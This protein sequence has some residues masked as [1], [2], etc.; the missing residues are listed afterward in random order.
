MQS[1][2]EDFHR[3]F[4]HPVN[5]KPVW[6]RPELRAKLI[7]E[8]A[9]ETVDAIRARNMIE[10]IDGMCDLL[11][12]VFGT[13]VEFGID[14]DVFFEE[15]HRANMT[16]VGGATRA[17][18]KTLK[19]PG[20]EPPMIEK[21]LDESYRREGV[22]QAVAPNE[23]CDI[24]DR[25]DVNGKCSCSLIVTELRR[26]ACDDRREIMRM[27]PVFNLVRRWCNRPESVITAGREVL[28]ND[29][30]LWR[31]LR[32]RMTNAIAMEPKR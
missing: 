28:A 20:W 11:Y 2:V 19:P 6:S 25:R 13:A 30:D 31:E 21:L 27:Q 24:H 4:G 32:D 15:V 5:D 3:K 22:R 26:A 18:G 17:D 14:L 1:L 8:E 16:K 12:V 23:L 7:E 9:K 29:A 10:A